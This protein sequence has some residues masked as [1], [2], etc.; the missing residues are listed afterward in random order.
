ML[1]NYMPPHNLFYECTVNGKPIPFTCEFLKKGI[2]IIS[3]YRHSE[4]YY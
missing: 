3:Q 1:M 2:P 4:Y